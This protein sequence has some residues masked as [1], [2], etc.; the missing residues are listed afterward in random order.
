MHPN[1]AFTNASEND[2]VVDFRSCLCR[3]N[4]ALDCGAAPATCSGR[5]MHGKAK[6][7][8]GLRPGLFQIALSATKLVTC[9]AHASD[10]KR[11][12][13]TKR[14][15]ADNFRLRNFAL[16]TPSVATWKLANNYSSCEAIDPEAGD[17]MAGTPQ[18]RKI[19]NNL[20]DHRS[21]LEPV[22]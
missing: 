21:E 8:R 20:S 17:V 19:G 3:G 12:I 16:L 9:Q 14:F 1:I 18:H 10:S 15:R 11:K 2:V 6:A 4:G 13:S 22:P 7:R 5:V